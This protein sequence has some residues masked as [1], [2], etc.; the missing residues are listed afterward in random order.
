MIMET[1]HNRFRAVLM[2]SLGFIPA[3]LLLLLLS[4]CT[5]L[6]KPAAMKPP[7]VVV[8]TGTV[9]EGDLMASILV[10]KGIAP[11]LTSKIQTNI[12]KSFDLRRMKPKDT[13][14]VVT[15]TNGVFLKFVYRNDP[16][17]AFIVD[18]SSMGV[19]S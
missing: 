8:S 3:L 18:R 9:K 6:F 5:G 2:A 4:K 15:S 13:Y 10:A 19:L 1:E 16:T 14:E 11:D 7:A 12:G 17:H